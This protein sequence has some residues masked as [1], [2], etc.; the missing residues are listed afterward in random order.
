[1]ASIPLDGKVVLKQARS[2]DGFSPQTRL[3]H[4]HLN[5]GDVGRS[6]AFYQE[7]GL[8][9]TADLYNQARFLSWDGYHHHLGIN[10]W[11]GRNASRLEP[12][13]Y[14]L[15]F[16]EISHPGFKPGTFD[17]ADVVKL[18]VAAVELG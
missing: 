15:D 17:D 1:M 6:A 18:V 12:D 4:M 2:F 9:L 10:V 14:G 7:L 3:G 5:V 16:F 11:A 8:D 13:V